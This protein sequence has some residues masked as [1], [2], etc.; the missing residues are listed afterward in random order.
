MDR[1]NRPTIKWEAEEQWAANEG[2]KSL[3]WQQML[4]NW[5]IRV[6]IVK[7]RRNIIVER[8]VRLVLI[9][10]S[11]TIWELK[12]PF[13]VAYPHRIQTIETFDLRNSVVPFVE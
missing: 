4:T 13:Q 8:C 9:I 6:Q 12:G 2:G 5:E 7:D 10:I 3:N 1:I 11:L